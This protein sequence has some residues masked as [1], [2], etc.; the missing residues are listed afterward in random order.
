MTVTFALSSA[1][2]RGPIAKRQ[3]VCSFYEVAV[4]RL[5]AGL[6]FKRHRYL[7]AAPT[8]PISCVNSRPDVGKQKAVAL[9][10]SKMRPFAIEGRKTESYS[11]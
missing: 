3:F 11:L 2:F 5:A 6:P 7:G 1:L 9:L 10:L 8:W 4:Q